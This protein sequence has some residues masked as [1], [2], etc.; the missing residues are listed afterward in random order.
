MNT[1]ETNAS[2]A[3][4]NLSDTLWRLDEAARRDNKPIR[5]YM[6]AR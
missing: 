4:Q 6:P 2:T 1:N 3:P 5:F